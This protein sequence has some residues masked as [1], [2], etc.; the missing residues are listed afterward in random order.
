M[1]QNIALNSGMN[2]EETFFYFARVNHINDR[3]F[4]QDRIENY[5]EMLGLNDATQQVGLLSGGQKRLLS[6]GVTLIYAPKILLL[7]E[8]TVGVDS[9]I[10]RKIWKHLDQLCHVNGECYTWKGL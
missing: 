8:P 9:L 1:P 4:V 3:H 2:I 6:L 7:D 10:R 5:L